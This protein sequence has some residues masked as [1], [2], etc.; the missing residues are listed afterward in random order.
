MTDLGNNK[1]DKKQ[2]KNKGPLIRIETAGDIPEE[3]VREIVAAFAEK[4]EI[5]NYRVVF[6]IDS[7][8]IGGF[9]IFFNGS[10]YDYSVKGQLDRIGSFMKRTRALEES[11]SIDEEFAHENVSKSLKDVLAKFPE[12]PMASLDRAELNDLEGEAFN[13]RISMA[14]ESANTTDEVGMVTGVSDGVATVSGLE[15][16]MLSELVSFT[17]GA[18]GIAMNLEKNKVGVVL[19]SGE[20]K[21][22]EGELCK[23]TETT[24]SVPVGN[25]LLGR[26]V[27]PLGHPID[28][29][30]II[31]YTETRPIESPAPGIVDR[32]PVCK[33]LATGI[34]A[35]DALT[36]IGRGQRELIIGDRQ[37]G[38]TAIAI[39]T[40]LNQKDEDVI[41]VYVAI[42]Q[43]MSNVVSTVNLLDKH[44]AL[45]YTVVVAA[46]ASDSAALQYIAPFSACA[47]AEKFM[48]DFHKDVLIIYDD[49][50]KH[51]QAYRAISLLLRRPPGREAYPGDVFYLHSRLLERAA[52]LSDALGG[53]SI[54]ALPIVETLGNDISAYIPTNVISITDGQI[55]LAPELFFS[56]QRPAINVGLSVS[57][58]GGAAQT[59]ATKKVGGPL[60]ISLAQA[61]EM[62]S[63]AQ[64]GSDL[65]ENTR[66]QLKRGEVMNEVL[67]Q[68]QFKPWTMAEQVVIL[69]IATTDKL[70]FL[71]KEDV[72][73]FYRDFVSSLHISHPRIM[74]KI[75]ETGKF[76]ESTAEQIDFVFDEFKE[77]YLAEHT[78]YRQEE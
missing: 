10:R 40:I 58:V 2:S 13:K 4:N 66:L 11:D 62:A 46:S 35:I 1:P 8:L 54:T 34:T 50:S 33:P 44:G 67:K 28:G 6:N 57:R 60:R 29:K 15:H 73:E 27:D 32:S 39:D 71:E 30:G 56:G 51:A 7:N 72:T 20:A 14:L 48:Y 63:F 45:P 36:P 74:N 17:S 31:R 42:G 9:I 21:V 38:K 18:T 68:E 78:E 37:T 77:T 3:K 76:E 55:Y 53:G 47:I 43:K 23:R 26:V 25:G 64:F 52:K 5:L 61:R 69:Y 75:T 41:C 12:T 16:C 22:T 49:L 70:N 59:K 24:V 65:D 19:L